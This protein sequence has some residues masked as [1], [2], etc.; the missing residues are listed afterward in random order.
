MIIT[1]ILESSFKANDENRTRTVCLEGRNTNHYTTFANYRITQLQTF[2]L[3]ELVVGIVWPLLTYSLIT[4]A[5]NINQFYTNF[6]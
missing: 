5:T 6:S 3:V 4:S 2:R 1:I